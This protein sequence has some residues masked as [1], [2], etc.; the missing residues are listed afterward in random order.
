[1]VWYV[2]NMVSVCC[3]LLTDWFRSLNATP[4][5]TKLDR[6]PNRLLACTSSASSLNIQADEYEKLGS[7]A[8]IGLPDVYTTRY[9]ESVHQVLHDVEHGAFGVKEH[10]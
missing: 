8:M 5:Q 6:P 3:Q 1:M 2:V 4:L 10:R 9:G 7:Y